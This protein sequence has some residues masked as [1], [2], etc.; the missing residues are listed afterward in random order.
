M[1]KKTMLALIVFTVIAGI[2]NAQE[3]SDDSWYSSKYY[4]DLSAAISSY[5]RAIE[6]SPRN[7]YAYKRRGFA[8]MLRSELFVR[9][10]FDEDLDNA[11]SDLTEAIRLNPKDGEAYKY[12]GA[13]F[14]LLSEIEDE[15][16][17]FNR[18]ITDLTE[19]VRL[20][21][22]DRE[23]AELLSEFK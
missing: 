11:I 23:A 7:A 9:N 2:A 3:E 8:Y 17:N 22:N 21:P 18:A 14:A 12:R 16:K 20:H 13:A 5:T 6:L 15:K 10:N 19:A 4:N 1:I